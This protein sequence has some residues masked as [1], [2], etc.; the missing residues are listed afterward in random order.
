MCTRTLS[1]TASSS[2]KGHNDSHADVHLL[3][4]VRLLPYLLFFAS[5]LQYFRHSSEG[6]HA[7]LVLP[8]R[9]RSECGRKQDDLEARGSVT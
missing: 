4:A 9:T 3:H 6:Y 1:L 8:S 7:V 5:T 2:R